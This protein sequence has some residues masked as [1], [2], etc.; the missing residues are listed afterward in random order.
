MN[1]LTQE[2]S[3]SL[4]YRKLLRSYDLC[5][6]CGGKKRTVAVRCGKCRYSKQPLP[7][8][9]DSSIRHIPL[10]KGK[11]VI[12]DASDY[13]WLSRFTWHATL[14]PY[15]ARRECAEVGNRKI[16]MMHRQI[17]GIEDSSC[18]ADHING[19]GLDN[20]RCNIRIATPIQNAGNRGKNKNNSSGYKGVSWCKATGKWQAG[21]SINRKRIN[22]G[23]T[24]TTPEDAHEAYKQA[25]IRHFGEFARC[26]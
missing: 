8:P 26:S 14:R 3:P 6:E 19:N 11:F 13:E 5:P 7:Q 4:E 16:V 20:R 21:I 17:L 2:T 22:L 25:A 24:F 12:V 18:Y 9:E 10:T 23:T 15:A 1:L